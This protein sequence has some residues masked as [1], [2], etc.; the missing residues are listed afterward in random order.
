MEE[1]T[2]VPI[3]EEVGSNEVP[4]DTPNTGR[5]VNSKPEA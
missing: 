3:E 4:T 1:E 5:F 2:N